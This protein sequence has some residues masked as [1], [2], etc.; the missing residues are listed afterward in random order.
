MWSLRPWFV[1][2]VIVI[3]IAVFV[4]VVVVMCGGVCGVHAH[5]YCS[6]MGNFL[7]LTVGPQLVVNLSNAADL[8]NCKFP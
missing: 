1:V 7:Y 5:G 4:V 6:H 2:F 3:V 8:T